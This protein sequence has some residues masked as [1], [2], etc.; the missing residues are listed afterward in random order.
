MKNFLTLFLLFFISIS[1]YAEVKVPGFAFTGKEIS[2][3]NIRP[4]FKNVSVSFSVQSNFDTYLKQESFR[5]KAGETKD[6]KGED[7]GDIYSGGFG[8]SLSSVFVGDKAY[9]NNIVKAF[10]G[11]KYLDVIQSYDKYFEKKIKGTD[12]EE[13]VRLVY[14]FALM[15]TGSISK[16]LAIL[17]DIANNGK[18]FKVVASDR[19]A[20]YMMSIKGFEELDIFIGGLDR[21]T[22]YTLYAWLYALLALDRHERLVKTF[23]SH[24][25]ITSKDTRFYDFYITA[26]YAQGGFEDVINNADKS[27][28]NTIGLVADAYLAKGDRIKAEE[29]IENMPESSSKTVLKGKSAILEGDLIQAGELLSELTSDEDRLNLFYYYIGK[30]FPSLSIDFLSQ[31]NFESRINADYLKF[32]TGIFYL[33]KGDNRKSIKFLD[34]VIFNSDLTETAYYYRGLAYAQI[35]RKRSERY[36]LKYIENSQDEEKITVSRFMLAQMAYIGGSPDDALMLTTTCDKDFCKLL[37]ARIFLDKNKYEMAWANAEGVPGDD[38][39]LIRA[40]VLF[41]KK[42]YEAALKQISLIKTKSR[43][44]DFLTMLCWLKLDKTYEAETVFNKYKDDVEFVKTYLEHLFLNGQYREV[45]KLTEQRKGDFAIIRAKSLFSMGKLVDAANLYELIIK[46]GQ[47]SFEAWNGLSST[48]IA[49]NEEEK[50]AETARRITNVKE[51]FDKKDFL[52]YQTAV[53]ALDFKKTKLATVLLNYFFDTFLRSAYKNDAYLLRGKLFRDTGRVKQCLNDAEIMLSEGRSED[54]LFLK[55][56]CLQSTKPKE[57]LKIFKE[58]TESSGRFR[59]LGYSKLI[60]LYTKPSDILK[61]V[62]YFKDKDT[63][64]YYSGLDIY[65]EKLNAKQLENSRALLDEMI[66]KRNPAGLAAAYYYLGVINFNN[67]KYETAGIMFMKS[68]YLFP[69]S[70]YSAKSLMMTIEVYKKLG[71]DKDIPILETKL[72]AMKR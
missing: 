51:N 37:R 45:L 70:K 34:S 47:H 68:H 60:E 14:S 16:S 18:Y 6:Y 63:V 43:D 12:F 61:A 32:Y 1:A 35:D 25:V 29:Y 56:E 28:D 3:F 71:R 66:N 4:S 19:V 53:Q 54:A 33:T 17:K 31:F 36:F 64:R 15:Q 13:E 52:V 67:K 7:P 69:T 24:P 58:M 5:L 42:Y 46:N 44:A 21:Q 72:K 55:G 23:D 26:R 62:N 50:F 39:G 57:A 20:Q 41:H 49:M 59:D 10:V 48:Y 27:T 30:S 2:D 11:N 40:T 65:L 22:P 38:A 8:T 9:R